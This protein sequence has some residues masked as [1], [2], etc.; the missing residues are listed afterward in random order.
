MLIEFSVQNFR[1]F[2]EKVTFSLLPASINEKRKVMPIL[3]EDYKDL[4][5]LPGAIL[6][7]PNNSGKSNLLLAVNVLCLLVTKSGSFNSDEKLSDD[8]FAFD[9]DQKEKPIMLE[10]EFIAPNKSRYH[11]H[12]SI[13]NNQIIEEQ[14]IRYNHSPAGKTTKQT[15]YKRFAQEISFPSNHLKGSKNFNFNQNQLF[16]SRGDIE[17]NEELQEVYAF[18]SKLHVRQLAEMRYVEYLMNNYSLFIQKGEDIKTKQ[19]I[20]KIVSEFDKTIVELQ[21]GALNFDKINFKS[22]MPD[23]MKETIFEKLKKETFTVHKL[24]KEGKEV[25]KVQMPLSRQSTG[26]RKF[27]AILP[28]IL[29]VLQDGGVL[30]LDELNVSLHT[31]ITAFILGL[32]NNSKTNPKHAQL[33]STTHDIMLLNHALFDRDQIYI[34]EKDEYGA[35]TLFSFSDYNFSNLRSPNLAQYYESGKVGGLPT[36]FIPYINSII[37]QYLQNGTEE[38]K[39]STT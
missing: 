4:A 23:E 22:D 16:L 1:S 38:Q 14:L 18:F 3:I 34:T 30:F 29:P 24:Y 31:E 13:L 9:I 2:K 27:L 33:I 32:F 20:D 26:M 36:L 39:K 35:S 6:Y 12:V 19:L 37:S 11:L 7:G 17:G 5:V 25:G 15:L 8:V 28:D 10:I 21:T